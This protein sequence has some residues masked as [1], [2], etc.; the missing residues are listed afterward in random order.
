MS[1]QLAWH[2]TTGQKFLQIV[3]SGFLMPT[4][5]HILPA[6]RPVLWFSTNQK[7][8][9]TGCKA[10]LNRRGNIRRLSMVETAARGQGLVRFGYPEQRLIAW[11][12]LGV[13]ANI[14]AKIRNDL[15]VSG[16]EQGADP[17]TWRGALNPI[18][19][20]HLVV[21]VMEERIRWVRVQDTEESSP[22]DHSGH[23]NQSTP[24]EPFQEQVRI[25][26][27]P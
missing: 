12:D 20:N 3:E 9:P 15:E 1:V 22:V 21:E 5:N 8:E 11:P 6:E 23:W 10:I 24:V 16:R 19:V 14:N 4:F 13:V 7:W 18:A 17:R 2:Y 25:A 26:I 27:H